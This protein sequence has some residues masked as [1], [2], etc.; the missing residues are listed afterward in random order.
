VTDV[1]I[2]LITSL[3]STIVNSIKITD[4]ALPQRIGEVVKLREIL[5]IVVLGV[6]ARVSQ[7]PPSQ[8]PCIIHRLIQ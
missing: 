4:G 3:R 8:L 5:V 7:R 1:R 2:I 6:W